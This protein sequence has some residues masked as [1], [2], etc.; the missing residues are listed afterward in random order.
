[1]V[2]L[3]NL[4]GL[5]KSVS[6]YVDESTRNSLIENYLIRGIFCYYDSYKKCKINNS[7]LLNWKTQALK[8]PRRQHTRKENL[9]HPTAN[10]CRIQ[11]RNLSKNSS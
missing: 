2:G 7:V 11:K 4:G 1:M 9:R 6:L 3:D 5:F 10:F 8:L